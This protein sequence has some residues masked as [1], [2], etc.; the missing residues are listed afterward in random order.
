MSQVIQNIIRFGIILFIQIFLL[1]SVEVARNTSLYNVALFKPF[2]YFLFILMLPVNMPRGLVIIISFLTGLTLD[3]YTNKFGLHA[4][5]SLLLGFIRPF[6]LNI[7]FNQPGKESKTLVTPSLVKMGFKNFFLYSLICLTVTITYFYIIEFWSFK[8][9]ALLT[10]FLNII[11]CIFT[12][13]VLVILSQV[14]FLDV[15]K[16]S[17]T[18]R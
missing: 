6:L 8:L 3:F 17:K 5:A 11:S 14:L 10:M 15:N 18:R 7:F 13:I 1:N 9:S 4:S 12:T 2:F 16:K